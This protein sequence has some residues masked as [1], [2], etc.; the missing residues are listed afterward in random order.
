LL[1]S[2][3]LAEAAAVIARAYPSLPISNI[4]RS[5]THFEGRDGRN[6]R[7]T[8]IRLIAC[9][10]AIAGSGIRMWCYRELGK[11]FTFELGLQKDHKLIT[12]G[13]YSIV[14]HPSYTAAILNNIALIGLYGTRG[15]WLRE[16][17]VLETPMGKLAVAIELSFV[18]A[19]SVA[20]LK[21]IK[22]EDGVLRKQFGNQWDAWA[23]KVP[24]VLLPGVI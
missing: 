20:L 11:H 12:T 9:L 19:I 10:L 15:S 22:E 8:T 13:P 6:M 2:A 3:T 18:A 23:A 24:Y 21:R 16:S 17:G 1:W 4:L 7:F 5:A 14:R